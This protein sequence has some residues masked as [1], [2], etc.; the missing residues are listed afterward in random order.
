MEGHEST[1]RHKQAQ[2]E[3][4]IPTVECVVLLYCLN[5]AKEFGNGDAS[6]VSIRKWKMEKFLHQ[7]NPNAPGLPSGCCEKFGNTT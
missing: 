1:H 3:G 6:G 7:P 5:T 4:E 2:F